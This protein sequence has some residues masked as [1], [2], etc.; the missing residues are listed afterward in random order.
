MMTT[1]RSDFFPKTA[2]GRVLSFLLAMYAFA[3]SGHVTATLATFFV[4]QDAES[5]DAELAGAKSIQALQA[6]IAALRTEVQALVLVLTRFS[7]VRLYLT[8]D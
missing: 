2:E 3:V 5:D 6:E 7:F 1:I 8:I 4:G